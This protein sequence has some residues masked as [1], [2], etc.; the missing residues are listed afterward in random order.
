M[1]FAD[2]A[3]GRLGARLRLVFYSMRNS[4]VSRAV[5][6]SGWVPGFCAAFGLGVSGLVLIGWVFDLEG[7]KS[8]GPGEESMKPNTAVAFFAASAALFL[9]RRAAGSV[10]NRRVAAGAAGL[11]LATGGL[12]LMQ[13]AAGVDL[14]IDGIFSEEATRMSLS[15]AVGLT[16]LGVA[17]AGIDH[18]VRGGRRPTHL[19]AVLAGL[20]GALAVF[21]YLYGLQSWH[22]VAEE[23]TL[24]MHSAATLVV[25]ALGVLMSRSGA[26]AL[27]VLTSAGPGG[28]FARW[29]LP[30][31]LVVLLGFLIWRQAARAD[32][33]DR[34][35]RAFAAALR[36]RERA[37]REELE[38]KVAERTAELEAASAR[39]RESEGL[40]REFVHHAP[41]A[42]AMLDSDMRYLWASE[43]WL[44]DYGLAGRNLTGR[45]H[46][47]VFPDQPAHWRE[48]HRRV[49]AGA[50]ERKDEE[51]FPRADGTVEW[52]QWEARPW[53][54]ADGGVGGLL[55]FTQ[56]ITARKRLELDLRRRGEEL[57]RSNRDLEQFAYVASHDLQEPLRAVSG[58]VQLLQRRHGDQLEPQA[59]ELIG[60]AV[61]GARRMQ[62][63][64]LDLLTYSRVGM[65]E[66]KPRRVKLGEPLAEALKNLQTAIVESGAL[67]TV[68]GELPEVMADEP[69]LVML[70]QNL[71][72]NGLKYAA[73]GRAPLVR[74]G[75]T[76]RQ[77]EWEVRVRDNGVGI[78]ERF[79][80][81]IFV[82]FQRLHTREEYSGTGIGL[83]LCK[84]IVE[85][86][87][88]RIWV[89]SRPGAGSEFCF[90]LPDSPPS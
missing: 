55:F 86:H 19:L 56:S 79:F 41:A 31:V 58:C 28:V 48:I 54:G 52:L 33:A 6:R 83:A 34:E 77:G 7:L 23:R 59:R 32:A 84:K 81:R 72:G 43:Q 17:L 76:R 88:G 90:T 26:G 51:A 29:L 24:S 68:E 14:G 65:G 21:G 20:V 53:L 85:R 89:E 40:L 71:V 30:V 18:T 50:V 5:W 60:H 12:T 8:L 2:A 13:Y 35:Q 61:D 22:T 10:W 37:A 57:E 80:E 64:I 44:A 63:L 47:E 39:L 25:L 27:H 82:I 87:G 73:P 62:T 42:I 66:L 36:E 16:A 49:L 3:G 9:R 38:A 4:H 45:S 11:T 74:V 75:A 1:A 69:R 70:L 15:A 78:E 46:Y 67:V